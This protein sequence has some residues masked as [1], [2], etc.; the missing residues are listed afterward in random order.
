MS[1]LIGNETD[2]PSAFEMLVG[3]DKK[4]KTVEDLAKGKAESDAYIEELTAKLAKLE[5]EKSK[6]D[7]ALTLLEELKKKG[8]TGEPADTSSNKTEPA[9][10]QNTS[11]GVS[12]DDLKSLVKD[13]LAEQQSQ[14]VA[15]ANVEKVN[16]KLLEVYGDTDKAKAAIKNKA[17]ELNVSVSYLED[18]AK[19]N[20][21]VFFK[22]I[23]DGTKETTLSAPHTSSR[24]EANNDRGQIRDWAYY[25]KL[26]RENPKL[27]RTRAIQK[28]LD[29]NLQ[30]MG[31]AKFFNK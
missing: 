1:G 8:E 15:K 4:F 22:L 25:T 30:K 28:E 19:G 18:V 13:A 6:G 11:D 31:S 3:E 9:D 21:T 2:Q 24:S 17:S 7:H 10:N 16:S 20:P 14:E 29:E 27:Y 23:S 5:E 12:A 26:R